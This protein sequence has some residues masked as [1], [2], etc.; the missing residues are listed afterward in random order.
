[1]SHWE[2]KHLTSALNK[3]ELLVFN[4][5]GMDFLYGSSPLYAPIPLRDSCCLARTSATNA[6]TTLSSG[7]SC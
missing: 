2:L 7:E 6:A 1:M 4:G 3:N 5:K